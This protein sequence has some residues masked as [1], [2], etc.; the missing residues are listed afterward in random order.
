M[1]EQKG[2]GADRG[3][4]RAAFHGL[5]QRT[6]DFGTRRLVKIA[7]ARHDDQVGAA[8]QLE[9]AVDIDANAAEA[10]QR[11]RVGRR[12]DETVGHEIKLRPREREEFGRDAE[13]EHRQTVGGEGDDEGRA[14][15]TW[16]DI[17]GL[18]HS[19]Q[20]K[21]PTLACQGA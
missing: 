20:F 16:P 5:A 18:W 7:P 17:T 12:D 15:A 3:D 6:G 8:Q 10:A 9:P 14:D 2:A 4:A 1:A 19:G 13:L 11:R 21:S